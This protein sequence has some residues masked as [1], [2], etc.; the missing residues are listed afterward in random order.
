MPELLLQPSMV[1]VDQAGLTD[2]IDYIIYKFTLSNVTMH[3]SMSQC[4]RATTSAIH[5]RIRPVS[6]TP[7]TLF[8][9]G[10]LCLMLRCMCPCHRV[11]E[12][13]L[14]PSMVGV[15]QAGL[16]DTI[17]YILHRFTLSNVTMHVSTSQSARAATPAIHDLGG[18][19][20][21]N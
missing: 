6:Q 10:S 15:D 3:V 2:T 8:F 17:D 11:P 16:T 9:T 13:L 21:T 19:G 14:Q 18:S 7:S 1:G 5:G 20:R 4:A 12:L